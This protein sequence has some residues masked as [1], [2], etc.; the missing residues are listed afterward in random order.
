MSETK[1]IQKPINGKRLKKRYESRQLK[2]DAINKEREKL[3]AEQSIDAKLLK[4]AEDRKST[5]KVKGLL[6]SFPE[7]SPWSAEDVFAVIGAAVKAGTT[8]DDVKGFILANAKTASKSPEDHSDP[9]PDEDQAVKSEQKDG[10]L[11]D[12]QSAT[13]DAKPDKRDRRAQR[14]SP[15]KSSESG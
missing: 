5:N 10:A 2:L 14:Q 12:Q 6:R 9:A 4:A 7:N 8:P 3:A 15:S 13:N 1:A 11:G